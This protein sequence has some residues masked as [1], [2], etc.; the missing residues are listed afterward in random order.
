MRIIC[1][2][3]FSRQVNYRYLADWRKTAFFIPY[4]RYFGFSRTQLSLVNI[5]KND[6]YNVDKKKKSIQKKKTI[7]RKMLRDKLFFLKIKKNEKRDKNS[8]ILL[9]FY[10]LVTASPLLFRQISF[11]LTYLPII[12]QKANTKRPNKVNSQVTRK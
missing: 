12:H 10:C 7:R 5:R 4:I 9:E 6:A 3:K 1:R 11:I 8:M 2:S